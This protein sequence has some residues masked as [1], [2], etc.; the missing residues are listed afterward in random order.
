MKSSIRRLVLFFSIFL[1]Y[2]CS[3]IEKEASKSN[4]FASKKLLIPLYIYPENNTSWQ[5]LVELKKHYP[6]LEIVVI[7]NQNNGQITNSDSN[8][9]RG[10]T[11]L[12]DANISTIGY[13]YTKF[14]NRSIDDVKQNIDNWYLFYGTY[15]IDGIFF[16]E[17]AYSESYFDY[18]EH[19]SGYARD[20][21]LDFIVFNPGR[22]VDEAYIQTQIATVIVSRETTYEKAIEATEFNT[23]S[24]HTSLGLLLYETNQEDALTFGCTYAKTYD[25]EYIYL[26]DDG[27]DGNPWDSFSSY[28]ERL[29]SNM[30][31]RC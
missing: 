27:V 2:G 18:Y 6:T 4:I 29:A 23:P 30:K 5:P 22:K 20:K 28:L 19:L 21:G 25:F 1:A 13:V 9:V 12:Q 17:G 15:G 8:F 31:E 14:G 26:T 16:D 10:L 11:Q 3:Y 7:V 24:L